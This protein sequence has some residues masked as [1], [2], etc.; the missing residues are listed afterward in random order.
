MWFLDD[1]LDFCILVFDHISA[2]ESGC[3]FVF[4]L[5]ADHL[6]ILFAG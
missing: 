5:I 1:V 3:C 6:D 2:F 4:W